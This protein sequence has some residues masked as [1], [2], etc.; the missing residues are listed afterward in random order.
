VIR[1]TV[2]RA[3]VLAA[4][5][6]AGLTPATGCDPISAVRLPEELTVRVDAWAEKNAAPSRSEAIRRLVE[7]ALARETLPGV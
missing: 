1:A 3:L 7:L 2:R 5:L 6:A 4:A